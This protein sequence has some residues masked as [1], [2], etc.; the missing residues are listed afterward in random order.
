MSSQ[1]RRKSCVISQTLLNLKRAKGVYILKITFIGFP[2]E[3]AWCSKCSNVDLHMLELEKSG[4]CS[5]VCLFFQTHRKISLSSGF[6]SLHIYSMFSQHFLFLLNFCSFHLSHCL[7]CHHPIYDQGRILSNPISFTYSSRQE[8]HSMNQITSCSCSLSEAGKVGLVWC[9][10]AWF[11]NKICY[12]SI[13]LHPGF[14]FCIFFLDPAYAQSAANSAVDVSLGIG[15]KWWWRSED[16]YDQL[17]RVHRIKNSEPIEYTR[18]LVIRSSIA[19][20]NWRA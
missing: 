6:S 11:W 20:L 2:L 14:Q 5:S 4:E 15:E 8:R 7:R 12:Q 9:A 18:A 10:A 19:L 13:V 17:N 16:F 3:H 1:P